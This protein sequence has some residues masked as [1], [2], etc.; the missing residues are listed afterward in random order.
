M[1][2]ADVSKIALFPVKTGDLT[3]E[4]M[5]MNAPSVGTFS[6]RETE[7]ITVHVKEPPLAGRPPGY[8]LGTVGQYTLRA[9][10]TPREV[11][12][13]G[14]IGVDIEISGSG[15]L[16]G[17]ITMPAIKGVEFSA[18][19]VNAKDKIVDKATVTGQRTFRHVVRFDRAGT[20]DLGE[21]TLPFYDPE[22][23]RYDVARATLGVINV[24]PSEGGTGSEPEEEGVLKGLPATRKA[25]ATI[26]VLPEQSY[27]VDKPVV[28]FGAL[29]APPMLVAAGALLSRGLRRARERLAEAK[30]SPQA[31]KRA[32]IAEG[33]A[34]LREK[35]VNA[36]DRAVLRAL[37]AALFEHTGVRIRGLTEREL[38]EKLEEADIGEEARAEF[39]RLHREAS[40]SR[41]SPD[42][43]PLDE[44][45]AR[46][47][48]TRKWISGLGA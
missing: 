47:A 34:A 48:S 42:P 44:V 37:D 2:S 24:T 19:E 5:S 22:N 27:I 38:Q 4:P 39:F 13:G 6:K 41:F 32:R 45:R 16:P 18:P 7:R 8:I 9:N 11:V 20:V 15:N 10:V 25:S 17:S 30:E 1:A 29:A 23:K 12:R 21:L 43:A 46:W 35:D 36:V 3:I 31:E 40:A 14:A 28:F 33:E 26:G